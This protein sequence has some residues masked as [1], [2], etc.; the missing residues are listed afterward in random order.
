[1][2]SLKGSISVVVAPFHE[3]ERVD[4]ASLRRTVD[5]I[6]SA[7]LGGM[8][9]PMYGTEFYK[10]TE[11]ECDQLVAAAIEVNAGRVPLIANGNHGS[12]MVAA[13]LARR[14]EKMGADV[15]S[16]ALPRMF[17][18]SDADLLRYCGRICDAVSLP[19]CIQDFNPGGTTIGPDFIADLHRAHPNFRYA[20][21]EE[22][23]LADKIVAIRDRVGDN[24]GVIEGWGGMYMLE[25]IPVGCCGIMPGVPIADALQR[26]FDD[27]AA[28]RNDEAYDL[29]G[30]LLPFINFTLQNMELFL[31]IEKHLL[32]RRGL[33]E[34]STC[35]SL[36]LTPSPTV[37]EHVEFLIAQLERLYAKWGI[38]FK[39]GR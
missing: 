26:V 4:E 5:W 16:F 20:K 27:R 10:L 37:W 15:V 28:G 11:A 23:L 6:A 3:D 7:G 25:A 38:P 36:A 12:A 31:Q 2:V 19:V 18:T 32:V 14:R 30:G 1:M 34:S 21:L 9:L 8:V 35:R 39:V 13:E 33:L 24:V 22:P 17:G 29:F